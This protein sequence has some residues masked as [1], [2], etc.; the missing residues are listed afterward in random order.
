M[1]RWELHYEVDATDVATGITVSV[2]G[3]LNC[4]TAIE[5]AITKCLE[6]VKGT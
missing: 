1:Y 3:Y 4:D 5:N 6:K 2:D